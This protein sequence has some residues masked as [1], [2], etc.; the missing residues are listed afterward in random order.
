MNLF[1]GHYILGDGPS[2]GDYTLWAMSV[3]PG[4][5]GGYWH[6]ISERVL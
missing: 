3:L 5:F 6:F 4:S 2:A 1:V